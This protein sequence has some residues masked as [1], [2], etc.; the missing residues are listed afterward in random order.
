MNANVIRK[1]IYPILIMLLT[2]AQS[3]CVDVDEYDDTPSDNTE[4]LWHIMDE[5]YCYFTEKQETLGVDWD[6][7]HTRYMANV[8]N[9]MSRTQ[10][11]EFLGSMLGELQDGHVN[12]GASFDLARNWSWKE[13]YA[14]NFSDSLQRRYLGTDYRIASGMYYRILD[15]NVG[16]VYVGSFSNS[17]G[18]GN[19][20]EVLVYLAS[21]SGIIIDVRDNGGGELTEAQK[22]AAHFCN[23]KT[24]VGYIRHKTGTGHDDLYDMEEQWLEPSTNV[25]WQKPVCVLTNRS[26]Y[27]AA[28]EFVKYMK[29]MPQVTV[30]GDQT[31]GGSG[32]PYSSEL[33][34]GWT[35]RFSAC[36]MYS[37]DKQSTEGGIEPDVKVDITSEDYQ[38]SIDTIIETAR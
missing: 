25:R 2:L 35:V 33:P 14:A 13:G 15:D 20:A 18:T 1:N 9:S 32:L 12:L 19:I 21:C 4:A 10:L 29:C 8:S 31:G 38:R 27:S 37:A 34:N 36:P 26:V 11:F 17:L 7:V 30:V 28:N 5:H 22:L 24:L 6:D 23:E 3:S 16:Y